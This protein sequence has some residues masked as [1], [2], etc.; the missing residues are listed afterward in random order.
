[1]K[2]I[3]LISFVASASPMFF[4]GDAPRIVV[5]RI[6]FSSMAKCEAERKRL[7]PWHSGPQ[8]IICVEVK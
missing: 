8:R 5:E 1:M 7:N 4:T 2:A 6:E 3:M